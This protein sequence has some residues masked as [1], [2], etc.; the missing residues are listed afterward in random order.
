FKLDESGRPYVVAGV[1]PD[2]F[3]ETGQLWGNPLSAWY[4]VRDDNDGWWI[5]RLRGTYELVDSVRMDHFRGFAACWEIPAG[6]STA[7]NGRWVETPGRE[8]FQ[9]LQVALGELKIIAE[10][11]GIITPDVEKLRDDFNF[12]GMRILQFAFDGNHTN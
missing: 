12:P 9:S 6:E 4:S 8:L 5:E 1:P 10:D 2:C 11:L 3:S 7:I